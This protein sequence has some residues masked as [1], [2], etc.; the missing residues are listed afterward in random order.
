M[1][2]ESDCLNWRIACE[3][4]IFDRDGSKDLMERIDSVFREIL[5]SSEKPMVEI[6]GDSAS[7]CGLPPFR[8]NRIKDVNNTVSDTPDISD[9]EWTNTESLIR[10]I[11]SDV[12]HIP[13][14]E[15][16]KNE[17]IFSLGLDSISAIKVSSLLRKRSLN[18]G[19]GEMLKAATVLKMAQVAD[20]K[21]LNGSSETLDSSITILKQQDALPIGEILLGAGINMGDVEKTLPCG[22]GQVYMLSRWQNSEGV[23]F[24]PTFCYQTFEHLDKPRLFKAWETL[25]ETTPIL[26]T[27]FAST[28]DRQIP[29]IQVILNQS[30]SSIN[31]LANPPSNE[32]PRPIL[33][34]SPV[35]LAVLEPPESSTMTCPKTTL[36][37][38]I[39]HALYDGVS[40]TIL[41]Q[42]FQD[43]YENPRTS[44]ETKPS[45]EDFLTYDLTTSSQEARKEFWS[46]YLKNSHHELL[47]LTDCK[48]NTSMYQWNSQFR[49]GLISSIDKISSLARDSNISLQALFLATYAHVHA[50]LLS[51]IALSNP[52]P[53]D[54]I[55]GIYLANRSLP[56][57]GLP[58]MAAPTL[59]LVPLLVRAALTTPIL[60][61][62]K[63][64]QQDLHAIASPQNSRVGLWEIKDLTGVEID[65]FVNFLSLPNALHEEVHTESP[66]W[67]DISPEWDQGLTARPK[68]SSEAGGTSPTTS[69]FLGLGSNPV[70]DAYRVCL[71]HLKL[72]PSTHIFFNFPLARIEWEKR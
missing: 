61:S 12:S 32:L 36:F 66:R 6:R 68:L 67:E 33:S 56:L 11:L 55:F 57:Q 14:K 38:T 30:P 8:I 40:L 69:K 2:L 60:Q 10:K 25:C 50:T 58:K 19:V 27:T 39:H 16:S 24:Y 7:V 31:W 5:E 71:F 18:L 42:R 43:L 63:I 41:L 28:E 59:N 4:S 65:C 64:I 13:E 72:S 52:Q 22:P 17:T 1:E 62:A 3:N 23:L 54:V 34:S 46:T 47:P 44:V 49:S 29:F 70:R 35:S 51:R 20:K 45:L 53:S 9:E 15:I 37:L 48:L 21:A 26:R